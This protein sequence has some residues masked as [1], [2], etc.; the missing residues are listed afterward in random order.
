V[1]SCGIV[2]L[3]LVF[4]SIFPKQR[5]SIFVS[6]LRDNSRLMAPDFTLRI[7]YDLSRVSSLRVVDLFREVTIG[8]HD[9]VRVNGEILSNFGDRRPE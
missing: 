5:H 3:R 4:V 7:L 9:Y 2:R 8:L 6:D 1:W